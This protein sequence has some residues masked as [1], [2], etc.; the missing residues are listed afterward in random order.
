MEHVGKHLERGDATHVA[1]AEDL[2]LKQWMQ[3]ERLLT[4]DGGSGWRLV[5]CDGR[6]NR[7]ESPAEEDEDDDA[8]ADA[9]ADDDDDDDEDAEGEE[10][11]EY[12]HQ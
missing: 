2:Y 10:D 9:D 1:E 3:Q 8:D 7:R 4:G 11:V 5:G 12:Q 6:R